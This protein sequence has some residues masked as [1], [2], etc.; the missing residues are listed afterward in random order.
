[1]PID[2]PVSREMYINVNNTP[3][4]IRIHVAPIFNSLLAIG[5]ISRPFSHSGLED[6]G[7][8]SLS[9]SSAPH[10]MASNSED[11]REHADLPPSYNKATGLPSYSEATRR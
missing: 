9:R 3:R 2:A 6:N 8:R 4:E 5:N 11:R 10:Y 7:H 1:M